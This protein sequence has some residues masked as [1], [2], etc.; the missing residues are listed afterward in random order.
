M[1]RSLDR[2]GL[3]RDA[4][5]ARV[6]AEIREELESHVELCA[7]A[8]RDQGHTPAEA[9][10][11]A[12]VRFGDLE[13]TLRACRR[14]RLGGRLAMQRLQ[15]ILILV[16]GGATVMLALHG[17]RSAALA[18]AERQ[19]AM[20]QA[21]MA[22]AL[23]AEMQERT[24]AEPVEQIVVGVGDVLTVHSDAS[25]AVRQTTEVQRDGQALFADVGWVKV[26]GRSRPEVEAELSVL[27]LAHYEDVAPVYVIVESRR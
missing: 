3:L 11:E 12:Q 25:S 19:H 16:L 7:E 13:R 14:V 15:W 24:P 20:V 1:E 10:R 23:L 5:A 2:R 8:L 21:E 9:L 22:R 6:E 27:Y 26:A 18:A 17:R 4:E